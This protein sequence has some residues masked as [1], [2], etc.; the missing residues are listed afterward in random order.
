MD[1]VCKYKN[2]VIVVPSGQLSDE[3]ASVK[4]LLKELDAFE[5]EMGILLDDLSKVDVSISKFIC[6]CDELADEIN[7]LGNAFPSSKVAAYAGMA[8]G[9]IRLWGLIHSKIKKQQAQKE[10][11]IKQDAILQ[12]K[13]QM[14]EERLPVQIR[15][16]EKLKNQVGSKVETLY[17]KGWEK[18]IDLSDPMMISHVKIFRMNISILI[19]YRYLS[20]VVNY[21]IAEMSAW[22]NGKQDSG[23]SYP[24]VCDLLANEFRTWPKRLGFADKSWDGL[25]TDAINQSRGEIPLPVLT[26]LAD[27]CLMRNYIGVN[28]GESD[29]CP[30]ALIRLD[31]LDY[32]CINPIVDSNPYLEHCRKVLSNDYHE[33]KKASGF[34]LPDILILLALPVA[35]LGVLCLIFHLE[36]SAFWRI[37]FIIPSLCWLGLGIEYYE[38]KYDII[39]P[40]V[41]RLEEYNSRIR[42]FREKIASKEDC[43]EFHVLG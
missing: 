10:Y 12:K 18:R 5:N 22:T 21:C 1:S 27:P 3:P 14:A 20:S 7:N 38:Q 43:K 6:R 30:D 33:P 34:G 36:S 39:F 9:P 26:V 25:M 8:S 23:L 15:Q 32:H 37:F 24:S 40:Y 2:S 35:F 17:S 11:Q 16:Y 31:S 4:D 13:K 29:N 41:K 42:K 28:I 19:K